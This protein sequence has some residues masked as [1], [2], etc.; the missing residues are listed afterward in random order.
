MDVRD[1]TRENSPVV[2]SLLIESYTFVTSSNPDEGCKMVGISSHLLHLIG[3]P[4]PKYHPI[5]A[6]TT[7]NS[8]LL[9]SV[10]FKICVKLIN[11]MQVGVWRM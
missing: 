11:R 6:A 9:Y 4:M 1:W 3:A 8:F 7:A 2:S 10:K 5:G